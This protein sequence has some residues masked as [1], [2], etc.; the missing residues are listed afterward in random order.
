MVKFG[1]LVCFELDD[2]GEDVAA[3]EG[4][5]LDD[6]GST[7]IGVF[8]VWDGDSVELCMWWVGGVVRREDIRRRNAS[9]PGRSGMER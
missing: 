7:G 2:T 9:V 8:D 6:E 5:I 3:L 4:E 1:M